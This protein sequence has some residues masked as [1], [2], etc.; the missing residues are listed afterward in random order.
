MAFNVGDRVRCV[1][2]Y[3][4]FD[5]HGLEG[6]EYT[7]TAL[8]DPNIDSQDGQWIQIERDG[9]FMRAARFELAVPEPEREEHVG[10]YVI[11]RTEVGQLH[12]DTYASELS[13][14]D[15]IEYLEQRH[16]WTVVAKKKIKTRI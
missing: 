7:V 14:A 1:Q 3:R 11:Y 6:N 8:R 12:A 4:A 10:Y 2:G 9:G 13:A 16:N 5:N 15:S